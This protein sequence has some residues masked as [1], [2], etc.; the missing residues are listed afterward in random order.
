MPETL[1]SL[2]GVYQKMKERGEAVTLI[3]ETR[4]GEEKVTLTTSNA[5][6]GGLGSSR[7]PPGLGS[8]TRPGFGAE[9]G[10]IWRSPGAWGRERGGWGG[11]VTA[12]HRMGPPWSSGRRSDGYWSQDRSL[13]T[14]SSILV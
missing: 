10:D 5:G 7:S 13:L 2:L 14:H 9:P 3:V 11:P 6:D 12:L 4:G 8:P 1:T